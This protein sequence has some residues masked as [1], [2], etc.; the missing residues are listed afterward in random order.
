MAADDDH[1][2]PDR[3]GTARNLHRGIADQ[4]D[5]L[6]TDP[7]MARNR[8]ASSSKHPLPVPL[9]TRR[10]DASADT[11]IRNHTYDSPTVAR[12]GKLGR[13]RRSAFRAA[14]DPSSATRIHFI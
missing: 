3:P 14:A 8:N 1:V 6:R 2:R 4:C 10:L 13:I 11:R 12:R 9:V 7:R 5:A